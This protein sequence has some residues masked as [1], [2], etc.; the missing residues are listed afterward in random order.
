MFKLFQKEFNK[1]FTDFCKNAHELYVT[2]LDKDVLYDTY[3]SSFPSGT[4]EIYKERSEHDCNCCKY[5]IR[6]YGGIVKI[7]N[8]QIVSIWES[9]FEHPYDVVCENL[10]KYVKSFPIVSFFNTSSIDAGTSSTISMDGANVIVWNHLSGQIPAKYVRTKETVG[11]MNTNYNVFTRAMKELTVESAESV[12]ELIDQNSLYRGK[13]FRCQIVNFKNIK[14]I[15]EQIPDK[16]KV[17]WC[18]VACLEDA[19]SR[20]RNTAI[21]T[22]LV[23]ISNGEELD[24]AV[25]KFESI[26][27][28]AN[29]KRPK[30]IFTKKMLKEA[31]EEVNELGFGPTLKRRHATPKDITV[32]NVLF[33]NR[34]IKNKILASP[35]D[36]LAESAES[37][38]KSFGKVQDVPAE[39]FFQE[40]V[41]NS[42]AV[43]LFLESRHEGNFVNVI[44]PEDPDAPSMFKW[45]N[46]FSWTYNGN[47]TDSTTK[48]LVKAA[49][50][51]VD[52]VLRFS[53][54]WN[55]SL[56]D[57]SDLDAHCNCGNQHIYFAKKYASDGGNLDVDI[58][59]PN[60]KVA[61]ENITWPDLHRMQ[62]G[63]YIFSVV[64]YG[65]RAS[66]GFS[67]E[68]EFNGQLYS[69]E[70]N[71]PLSTGQKVQVATVTLKD[72][73]FTLKESI[74]ISQHTGISKDIYCVKTNTFVKVPL[75][76]LSPNY[77]DGESIGNKHY[78]FII[79]GAKCLDP[80]RGFF[81]EFL[82]PKL[83]PHRR[84]F[85]AL[86]NN[87]MVKFAREQLCGL[88][89]SS[90]IKNDVLVKVT[91]K[92]QRVI[93]VQF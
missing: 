90:T 65:S 16:E 32:N 73:V 76:M 10:A 13:E 55:D 62:D 52:G 69:F 5:F 20:I 79:D 38:P 82:N 56:K 60:G 27:A 53:I 86:G 39:K 24:S 57:N 64:C 81:N 87:M 71:Q 41:P 85:E 4:N 47:I 84:V 6:N 83:D 33:V 59:Y 17:N 2:S 40:I 8:N 34:E 58:I 19:V 15:Y 78:F 70:Y 77:W 37:N 66:K 49:G 29:Y 31:E 28:P 36:E 48:T 91:G 12:I 23:D 45:K 50:G 67:A 7:E 14:V 68:I 43:E 92:T 21:G 51:K 80:I 26:M 25:R 54:R 9:E 88:G 11:N 42:S 18:W 75:I 1:H 61:V 93:R 44:A 63:H 89:F 72:G 35:F 30:P 22:L 46:G 3:L 74:N